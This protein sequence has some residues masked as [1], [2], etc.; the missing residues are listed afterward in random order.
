MAGKNITIA[1]A[2]FNAVPSIDVPVSGGGTASFV[3]ISDTTAAAADVASGKYFYTAAGVKTEGTASGGGG[4]SNFVKGTFKGT[5][6]GALQISLPYTGN[7]YP[8]AFVIYPTEGAY[9]PTGTIYGLV[10]RYVTLWYAAIKNVVTDVPA[11]DTAGTNGEFTY[12]NR[13]KNSASSATNYNNQTATSM[14]ALTNKDA[15]YSTGA[16]IVKFKSSTIMSVYITDQA[17][18]GFYTGIEYT[19]NVIYSS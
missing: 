10:K 4:A 19:Y 18:Y 2:V 12:I 3:E 16:D 9:D 8:V 13:H 1:G 11:F 17:R 14:I 6:A 5:A 7:G 15:A